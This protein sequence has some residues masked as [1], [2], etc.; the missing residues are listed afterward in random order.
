MEDVQLLKKKP[1]WYR[2]WW[3]ILIL[4]FILIMLLMSSFVVYKFSVIYRQMRAGSYVPEKTEFDMKLLTDVLSPSWGV[5]SAPI[6][7]V[8]FGDFNC[9]HL[10]IRS[11]I[12]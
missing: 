7:I 11:L 4:V 1:A 10:L 12:Y 9:S 3:G 2:R 5:E 8:E 6:T